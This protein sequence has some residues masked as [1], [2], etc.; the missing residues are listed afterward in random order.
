MYMELAWFMELGFV[1][2]I[3]SILWQTIW[4]LSPE[5][6][7]KQSSQVGYHKVYFSSGITFSLIFSADK[8]GK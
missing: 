7:K 1:V 8:N 5:S 2:T 3:S 4:Y 6:R